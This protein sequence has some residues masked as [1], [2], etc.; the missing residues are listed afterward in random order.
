MQVSAQDQKIPRLFQLSPEI[1]KQRKSS[2]VVR[3][4]NP[5]AIFA[6]TEAA[7]RLN[8]EMI[9]YCS[10]Q[11]NFSVSLYVASVSSCAFCQTVNSEKRLIFTASA[12]QATNHKSRPTNHDSQI[13]NHASPRG[14]RS[15]HYFDNLARDRG[16]ADLVHVQG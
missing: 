15:A 11:G 2:F 13:T 5:S 16:L 10:D 8:C 6:E 3:R 7:D 1:C 12:V 14:R 4:P 9:P